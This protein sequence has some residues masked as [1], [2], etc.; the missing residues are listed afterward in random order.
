[1]DA[2]EWNKIAAAILCALV[3]VVG[4]R[5]AADAVLAPQPLAKPA[6][7]PPV[8]PPPAPPTTDTAADPNAKP[9]EGAASTP[10]GGEN[11]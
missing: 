10:A 1:M 2:W 3:V 7:A 8:P 6:Y 9:A 5:F 11:K 4:L